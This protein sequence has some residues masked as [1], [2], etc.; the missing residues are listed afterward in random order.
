MLEYGFW[1]FLLIAVGRLGELVPG[2]AS[3]P[4]AKIALGVTLLVLIRNWKRMPA[5]T[6][7]TRPLARTA[8][9]LA[10]LA[11]LLT[12]ISYW[13]G[14]SREFLFAQFP[15]LLASTTIAYMMCHS[16]RALRGTLLALVLSGLILARAAVSGYSGGRA[17]ANTMYDTNDLA[18]LLVTVLPLVLAFAV[19]ARSTAKRF[20]YFG[21]GAIMLG[22]LLLTQSR[23]GFLGLVLVT[24]LA[25]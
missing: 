14:A 10:V 11:V 1:T 25:C 15:T 7:V 21:I 12:P 16:W 4:I 13:K 18:Y 17:E 2:L 20:M 19:T 23:G 6:A 22:A 9:I 24:L 5:K 8:I 3:L